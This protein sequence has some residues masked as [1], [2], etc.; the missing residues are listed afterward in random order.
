LCIDGPLKGANLQGM[1]SHLSY[2][3]AWTDHYPDTGLYGD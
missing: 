3:F 2:W 1:P